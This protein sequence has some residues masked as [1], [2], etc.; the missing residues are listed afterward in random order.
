MSLFL[1]L[2]IHLAS[3][4]AYMFENASL[5]VAVAS[6]EVRAKGGPPCHH[7]QWNHL[8]EMGIKERCVVGL[9]KK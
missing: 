5:S 3:Y 1:K 4:G 8:T 7:V 6:Q 9:E 2:N